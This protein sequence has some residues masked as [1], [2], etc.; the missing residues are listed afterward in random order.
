MRAVIDAQVYSAVSSVNFIR[1]YGFTG[2][3]A[4]LAGTPAGDVLAALQGLKAAMV[5][6]EYEKADADGRM[7]PWVLKIP[8]IT[9]LPIPVMTVTSITIELNVRINLT[10]SSETTTTQEASF[11]AG[12]AVDVPFVSASAS[13]SWS[14][15]RV[16]REGTTQST[17]YSVNIRME[18]KGGELPAG[19]D[20][21]LT[22]MESAIHTSQGVGGDGAG[23]GG[24]GS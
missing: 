11:D 5:E 9:M 1:K 8:F 6:F 22:T 17:E 20:R 23:G 21:L 3:A 2:P 12:A 15:S 19:L 16:N 18:A 4:M 10:Q 13:V 7:Q 14:N 24:G